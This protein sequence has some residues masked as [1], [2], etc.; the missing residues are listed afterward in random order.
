MIAVMEASTARA[1]LRREGL[2]ERLVSIAAGRFEVGGFYW[3]DL[4]RFA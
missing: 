4:D 1:T 2:P 3:T